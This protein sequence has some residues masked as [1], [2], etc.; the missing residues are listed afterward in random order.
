MDLRT[1]F[2]VMGFLVMICSCVLCTSDKSS[3]SKLEINNWQTCTKA[4]RS[5]EA[6]VSCA[7]GL[8]AITR[9]QI[10]KQLIPMMLDTGSLRSYAVMQVCSGMENRFYFK[11]VYYEPI[12][13]TVARKETL[14]YG[15]G[16]ISVLCN[17]FMEKL[18]IGSITSATMLFGGAYGF[19][20]K[21]MAMTQPA[22]LGLAG[23]PT[24]TRDKDFL[25]KVIIL[26]M[27]IFHLVQQS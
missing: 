8:T 13:S 23:A 20:L 9:V 17:F 6:V 4:K 2:L 19:V 18:Q 1:K 14:G 24:T 25:H 5:G 10:D 26:I 15:G 3:V 16:T 7:L 11:P 12:P 27:L 21:P 22:I